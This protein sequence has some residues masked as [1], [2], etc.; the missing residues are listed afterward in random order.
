[1]ARNSHLVWRVPYAPGAIEARGFTGQA[2]V[3][4]V[5]RETTGAAAGIVLRPD[6]ASIG[7]NGEDVA[8]IGVEIVDSAGRV[9]PTADNPVTFAITG[10]GHL[11]GVGNGDPSS[12]E[13]DKDPS[14]RAFNGL[15]C[16]IVQSDR[17]AGRLK[18]EATSPGLASAVLDITCAAA[19]PRPAID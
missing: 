16:V 9:V 12:H 2:Q 13:P 4:T 7:A 18:V 6:R 10:A 1:M 17:T 11:L 5:K 3:M 19:E 8:V 15:C 14:R